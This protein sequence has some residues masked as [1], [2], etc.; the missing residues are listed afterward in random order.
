MN[1]SASVVLLDAGPTLGHA[2]PLY[3][4]IGKDASDVVI[5]GAKRSAEAYLDRMA[6]KFLLKTCSETLLGW[7]QFGKFRMGSRLQIKKVWK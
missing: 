4:W 7:A 1:N 3:C 5:K 2:Y 6:V